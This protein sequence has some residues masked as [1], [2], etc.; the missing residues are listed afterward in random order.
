MADWSG[1]FCSTELQFAECSVRLS[2]FSRFCSSK[3]VRNFQPV[4]GWV[5]HLR[6]QL[7]YHHSQKAVFSRTYPVLISISQNQKRVMPVLVDTDG[8]ARAREPRISAQWIHQH[9]S[10]NHVSTNQK[11]CIFIEQYFVNST[12]KQVQTLLVLAVSTKSVFRGNS[13]QQFVHT[14]IPCSVLLYFF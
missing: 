13:S 5:T 7:Q 4:P 8:S 3:T 1:F 12:M 6:S 9:V 2:C 10:T 14:L 11:Q